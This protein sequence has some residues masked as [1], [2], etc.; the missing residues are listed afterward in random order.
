MRT[1]AAMENFIFLLLLLFGLE[2]K[3]VDN[4]AMMITR[5]IIQEEE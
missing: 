4:D 5:R 2:V 3:G 1:L